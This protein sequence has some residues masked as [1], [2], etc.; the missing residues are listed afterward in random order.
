MPTTQLSLSLDVELKTK[1]DQ[2]FGQIGMTTT[3]AIRMF[4]RQAAALEA[5]PLDT[6][7]S[8][9]MSKRARILELSDEGY[10]N[11][12][13]AMADKSKFEEAYKK[14]LQNHEAFVKKHKI[15]SLL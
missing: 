9:M 8:S 6:T 5:L 4:L 3:E 11:L 10:E 12:A 15:S 2:V 13:N 1:V 14:H 7:V